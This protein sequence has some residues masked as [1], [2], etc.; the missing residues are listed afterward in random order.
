VARTGCAREAVQTVY[1]AIGKQSRRTSF[2]EW[3]DLTT[4]AV[5]DEP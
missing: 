2:T 3:L 5:A 1:V 4:A